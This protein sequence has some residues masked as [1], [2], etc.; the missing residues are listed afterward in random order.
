MSAEGLETGTILEAVGQS[1]PDPGGATGAEPDVTADDQSGGDSQQTTTQA[2]PA[3]GDPEETF[4]DPTDLSPELQGRY[5]EMQAAFTKKTQAVAQDRQ[6]IDAYNAFMQDPMGQMQELAKQYGFS[7]QQ[8]NQPQ[9]QDPYGVD[10]EPQSWD[11][12]DAR[13]EA[14]LLPKLQEMLQP[15]VKEHTTIKQQTIEQQLNS[16]DPN[17][18]EHEAAMMDLLRVHPTLQAKPEQLYRLAVPPEVLENKATQRALKKLQDKAQASK[19][20]GTSTT[21]KKT[22]VA[23]PNRQ[24]RDIYEA[25]E[26]AKADLARRGVKAPG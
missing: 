18:K 23:D 25:A 6:K 2:G 17:W 7:I 13:I 1:D 26:W 12:V 15:I 11:D 24:P 14:R 20:S 22:P 5:K 3:D 8:A 10:W 19:T 16:I 21:N 9:S 4:F